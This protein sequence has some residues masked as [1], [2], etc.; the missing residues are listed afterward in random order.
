VSD[1]F[2][3]RR[4]GTVVVSLTEAETQLL[5]ELPEQLRALY[6][7]G[8]GDAARDRLF[9]RAYLDPT[10]EDAEREWQDLVHPELLRGRLAALDRL[11]ASLA[12]G[13]VR[14]G[15]VRVT[16]SPDEGETWVGVLNDARLALGVRLGVTEDE[17]VDLDPND[18]K[19][20]VVA[21]YSWLTYLQGDLVEA[22]LPQFDG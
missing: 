7:A 16:L 9:P 12:G 19:A 3:R 17:P 11:A 10:E 5:G 13:D 18:P 21:A 6:A 2:R 22:L 1:R 8:T 4:D 14:R 15:R 20:P